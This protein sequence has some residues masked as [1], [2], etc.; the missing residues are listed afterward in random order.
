MAWC[1]SCGKTIL[2]TGMSSLA[3]YAFGTDINGRAPGDMGDRTTDFMTFAAVA[4][5][6]MGLILVLNQVA[7]DPPSVAENAVCGVAAYT[8]VVMGYLAVNTIEDVFSN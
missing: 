6:G 5:I 3:I 4:M 7:L 1:Q 2:L 8:I